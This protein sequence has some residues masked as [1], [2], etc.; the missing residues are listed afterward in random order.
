MRLFNPTEKQVKTQVKFQPV[1]KKVWITNMNEERREEIKLSDTHTI[2]LTFGKKKILTVEVE[3][4][5]YNL[6]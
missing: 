1:I 6:N 4:K 3:F 2:P 5:K